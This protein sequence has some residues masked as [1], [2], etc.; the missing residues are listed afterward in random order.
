MHT[1]RY[2]LIDTSL[3]IFRFVV[4]GWREEGEG[5]WD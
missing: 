3:T 5:R 4:A 2:L 1:I